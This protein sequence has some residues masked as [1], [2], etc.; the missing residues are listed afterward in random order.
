M[1]RLVFS[2]Q[3][4]KDLKLLTKRGFDLATLDFVVG[5]LRAGQLLPV[6][7]RDHALIGSLH[8]YR[9]CHIRANW[10]LIY[11]MNEEVVTLVR[12]GSHSDLF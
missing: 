8:K 6:N 9:E 11:E 7:Y 12:T 2:S 1:K 5:L 10:L 3:C 4:K